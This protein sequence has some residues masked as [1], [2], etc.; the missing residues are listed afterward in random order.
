MNHLF[1]SLF[2]AA[3]H[4]VFFSHFLDP[5]TN[6]VLFAA[7]ILFGFNGLAVYK[8]AAFNKFTL[9]LS[10]Y[11]ALFIFIFGLAKSPLLFTL[12]II[13]YS[14][15]FNIPLLLGYLFI[16]IFSIGLLTPYWLQASIL[17]GLLY[18]SSLEIY[19]KTSS[20]FFTLLF[21]LGFVILSF[22]IF[23]IIL[24]SLQSTPQALLAALQNKEFQGALMNSLLT[25]TI[26]T[27][28]IL[29]FGVP[30]AY[31]LTRVDFKGKRLIDNLID[32]PILIPQT[33][34][35]I[36]ILIL[37]GPKSPLGEFIYKHCNIAIAGGYL[38][39]VAT[40]VFVSSPFL[41]R[42]AMGAF[43]AVD[44]Q[45][46][47]ASRTLG[48]SS[49]GTFWRISLPLA[50]G[51]IFNGCVLSWTRALSEVGSLMVVAYHPM[52]VSIY[53]YD[54]F[55]QYGLKETQPTAIVL[56][57]VCLWAFIAL[58]WYKYQI[59]KQMSRRGTRYVTP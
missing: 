11:L 50:A 29:L 45:L 34:S 15:I 37:L 24:F 22:I 26:S 2:L 35:G 47:D 46:E 5:G 53:I 13:L 42:S 1:L 49:C 27:F 57:V 9:Y 48:A 23:P 40:Q 58:R 6:A 7:N 17:A 4:L 36:A 39:I 10:G 33:V 19:R 3:F 12:F 44:P 14:A 16:L 31:V 28:I 8:K 52:T 30:L 41:I 20:K 43:E 25:S 59:T 38:G 21:M 54:Q 56:L 18:G 32:L 51:G 55:I